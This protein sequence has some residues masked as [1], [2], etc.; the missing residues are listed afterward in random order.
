MAWLVLK[1]GRAY[2]LDQFWSLQF[3]ESSV[4]ARVPGLS[5][6]VSFPLDQE[7]QEHL[8]KNLISGQGLHQ[9]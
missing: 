7:E 3:S 6:E 4:T 8:K 9:R 1:D 5:G 2:N